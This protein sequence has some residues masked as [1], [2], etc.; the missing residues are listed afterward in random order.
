M[1]FGYLTAA[2]AAVDLVGV[3]TGDLDA[4]HARIAELERLVNHLVTTLPEDA[5]AAG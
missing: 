2:E 4:A 3:L 5:A 1:A